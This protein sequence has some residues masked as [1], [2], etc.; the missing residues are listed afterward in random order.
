[1]RTRKMLGLLVLGTLALGVAAVLA[2]TLRPHG[3]ATT[4]QAQG[5]AALVLDMNADN[6]N[7]PCDP[8]DSSTS[9]GKGA[10]FKV[11]VCLRGA[12][13]APSAFDLY[14]NNDQSLDQ[15][16]PVDCADT[17]TN[18]LDTN[19]D[20]NTGATTWGSPLGTRWDCSGV[21]VALPTC[22]SP[23]TGGVYLGC[24]STQEPTLPF[25]P[26]VAAPLAVVTFKAIAEG[27][28]TFSL[29]PKYSGA[30]ASDSSIVDCSDPTTCPGGSVTIAGVA[31]PTAIIAS[32]AT[33]AGPTAAAATAAAAEPTAAAATAAAAAATAVAQGTPIAVVNQAA[34]AAAAAVAATSAAVATKTAAGATSTPGGKATATPTAAAGEGGD[35]S[36]PNAAVI[37]AIVVGAVVVVGGG[38]W[39]AW[40]RLR[41]G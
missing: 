31:A 20:A 26:E 40:R 8:I 28:D 12:T 14:V 6:G 41:A 25:G 1:M 34:T 35:S 16:I 37:A 30:N 17:D 33:A 13:E 39:F 7:G 10:E 11:A 9:V 4:A 36:G 38:G 32:T 22:H 24:F 2:M 5:G 21:G 15:C 27:T 29:D 23:N 3:L 19:P 18:C